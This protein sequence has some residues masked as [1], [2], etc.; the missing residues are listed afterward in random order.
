MRLAYL[1]T[2][3]GILFGGT[4]G[5][6]VHLSEIVAAVA[7]E[8]SEV[9]ALVA[10]IA[11]DADRPP[12][13]VRVEALPLPRRAAAGERL[14]R[15]G[16][17]TAWLVRRLRR[18]RATALYERLALH[19]GAGAAAATR[20]G[21]PHLVEVNAPLP[22][23]A[24]RYR[25][26]EEPESADRLERVVLA[27]ADV[28]LP[29]S[30]P[31]ARYVRARGARRVEVL[32]NAA[33]IDRFPERGR[34]AGREA[35]ALFAGS[36]RPWHGIEVIASAWRLLGR[37]APPLVVVGDGPAR[38]ILE[39]TRA[40]LVGA[41]P[42]ARMPAV[43]AT[44]DIGLAP[45]SGDAPRYFSPLKVFEYL[46]AGLATIVADLPAVTAV[47]DRDTALVVPPG[48][49][50]ALAEAVTELAA[51]PGKRRR[52][53]ANGRALVRDHHT[54]RH[55]ARRIVHVAGELAGDRGAPG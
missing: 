33:A 41:V 21:I 19:S 9:L 30:P 5:A 1:S 55:R 45:Y 18:F 2:D 51:D 39:G 50:S 12:G 27:S 42:P 43:L 31:L 20:L 37:A 29:V 15:D 48:D 13:R 46:A 32:Q 44:A 25:S 6:A 35:V 8:G 14:R 10:G 24:E 47:V 17:L 26:L 38:G 54:W 3:P 7:G 23:E 52:L 40:T 4:K 53:G 11:P 16:E 22:A 28:V 34:S 36:L 49:A